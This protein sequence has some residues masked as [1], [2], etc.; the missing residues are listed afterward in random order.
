[1][2]FY[3]VP[4][5]GAMILIQACILVP[6]VLFTMSAG[7]ATNIEVPV[8]IVC[9]FGIITLNLADMPTKITIPVFAATTFAALAMVLYNLLF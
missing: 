1:M 4:V 3:R 2:Q 9:T 7:Q 6:L 8:M 5:I